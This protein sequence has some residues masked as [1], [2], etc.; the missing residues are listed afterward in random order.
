MRSVHVM[1]ACLAVATVLACSKK[2]ARDDKPPAGALEGAARKATADGG[3]TNVDVTA[4]LDFGDGGTLLGVWVTALEDA[5]DGVHLRLSL[6]GPDGTA[7]GEDRLVAA[8]TVGAVKGTPVFIP[9]DVDEDGA[10]VAQAARTAVVVYSARA[11]G[12]LRPTLRVERLARP[13]EH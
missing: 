12:C 2:A 7:V 9:L 6:R 10:P 5:P 8:C 11:S 1:L 13:A 4:E 3:N